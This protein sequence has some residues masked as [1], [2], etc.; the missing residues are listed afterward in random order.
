MHAMR[1]GMI[2]AYQGF[3]VMRIV[4]F[5]TVAVVATFAVT[6]ILA[7]AHPGHAYRTSGGAANDV[8]TWT[9][10]SSGAQTHGAFVA[11]R[12]WL[13]QIR[14]T[15]GSLVRFSLVDLIESD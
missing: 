7:L 3:D 4:P 5:I 12:D 13:I 15:E 14:R 10:A 11:A 1:P 2:D 8:R 9:V 6:P